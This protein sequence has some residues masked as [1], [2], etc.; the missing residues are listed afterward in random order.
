MDG[1]LVKD[2]ESIVHEAQHDATNARAAVEL[3]LEDIIDFDGPDDRQNP[4]NWSSTYKWSIVVL[5][6]V[7]SLIV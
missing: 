4:Q 6:S 5:I 7:L 1:D 3:K 2:N